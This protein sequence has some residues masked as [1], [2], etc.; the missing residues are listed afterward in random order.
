VPPYLGEFEQLVLLALTRLGD[1]AY[2]IAIRDELA[3]H[4]DRDVS[5]AAVYKTL[6]RLEEKGL[7][8]SRV[9]EPTAVRGGRAKRVY[10]VS[11]AGRDALRASLATLRS[12][13]RGVD[14]LV[15]V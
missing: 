9:G 6:W 12:L 2:G 3:A 1:R 7:V 4:T 15:I 5:V 11:A 14:G 10:R 13:A 8:L